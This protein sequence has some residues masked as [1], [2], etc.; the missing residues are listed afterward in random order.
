M[1]APNVLEFNTPCGGGGYAS[2]Y[3]PSHDWAVIV[4]PD[5]SNRYRGIKSKDDC[6]SD[7]DAVNMQWRIP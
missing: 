7:I 2:E 1:F 6:E 4:D 3:C 5:S